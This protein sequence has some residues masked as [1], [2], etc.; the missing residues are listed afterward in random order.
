MFVKP[1]GNAYGVEKG[2]ETG[3]F[4]RRKCSLDHWESWAAESQT[5]ISHTLADTRSPMRDSRECVFR[6]GGDKGERE[7]AKPQSHIISSLSL[8]RRAVS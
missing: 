6:R 8:Q 2:K 3:G 1:A 4:V 7:V 5:H